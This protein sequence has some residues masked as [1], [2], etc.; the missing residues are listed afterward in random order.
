MV[1]INC[2]LFFRYGLLSAENDTKLFLIESELIEKVKETVPYFNNSTKINALIDGDSLKSCKYISPFMADDQTSCNFYPS[3]HVGSKLGTGLVHIAP[4]LGQDDFKLAIRHNLST[5]CAI[6]ELGRYSESDKILTK[7]NLSG[8]FALDVDTTNQIKSILSANILHHHTQV[9]SYPYDWRTKKPCIIRS[10]MQ[11]FI[12]TKQL[13]EDSLNTIEK[14]GISPA[15]VK[16]SMVA[17]LSSRPYWCI[18]RQRYWGLPIPCFYDISKDKEK[19]KPLINKEFIDRLK[20]FWFFNLLI[21]FS[22]I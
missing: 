7:H 13:K 2:F 18:S 10:S 9:H 20:R 1:K 4:A 19:K 17:P 14:V 11:W 22:S 21:K 6:D 12:D 3:D 8:K 16:T 15:N 5:D